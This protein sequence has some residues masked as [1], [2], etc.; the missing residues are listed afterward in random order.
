MIDDT[1]FGNRIAET[2]QAAFA[3]IMELRAVATP[4]R[5]TISPHSS[6]AWTYC[7][8]RPFFAAKEDTERHS[9][10]PPED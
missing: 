2:R 4:T 1:Q 6:M 5:I 3:V 9:S 8:S 7:P 10:L